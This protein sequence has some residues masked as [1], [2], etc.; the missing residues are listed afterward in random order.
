MLSRG[1]RHGI[2][3]ILAF[4]DLLRMML[5]NMIYI[6]ATHFG[7]WRFATDECDGTHTCTHTGPAVKVGV[8]RVHGFHGPSGGAHHVRPL[9]G[10]HP[11]THL[12]H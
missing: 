10:A 4:G 8:C 6:D 11:F 5:A 12:F 2:P 1:V 7:V 9:V 3:L